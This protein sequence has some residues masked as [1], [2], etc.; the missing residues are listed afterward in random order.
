MI[1]H[2]TRKMAYVEFDVPS[3]C[4]QEFKWSAT[5]AHVWETPGQYGR[6]GLVSYNDLQIVL[7]VVPRQ[8]QFEGDC[9]RFSQDLDNISSEDFSLS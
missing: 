6:D 5:T 1:K 9:R 2:E 4:T 3:N 7:C 8:I